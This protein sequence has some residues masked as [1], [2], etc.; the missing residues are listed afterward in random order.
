VCVYFFNLFFL[1]CIN[2]CLFLLLS[3]QPANSASRA[4]A[5]LLAQASAPEHERHSLAVQQRVRALLHVPDHVPITT[6][7]APAAV[8]ATTVTGKRTLQETRTN[9]VP[10]P[11]YA[12]QVPHPSAV[13]LTEGSAAVEV[14][15]HG[16]QLLQTMG[17]QEGKALG[18]S[19]VAASAPIA[20]HIQLHANAGIGIAVSSTRA[21]SASSALSE[22]D[23]EKEKAWKRMMARFNEDR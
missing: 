5:A 1:C 21:A 8:A 11:A 20:A 18:K 10:T 23:S 2:F 22:L 15:N 17:W 6:S 4:S 13:R 9:T 3:F 16:L 19:G 12:V 7:G 14:T